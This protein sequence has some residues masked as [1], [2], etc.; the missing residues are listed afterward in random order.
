MKNLKWHSDLSKQGLSTKTEYKIFLR[1]SNST[2][3]DTLKWTDCIYTRKMP[4]GG[5]ACNNGNYGQMLINKW[6]NKLRRLQQSRNIL[7]SWEEPNNFWCPLGRRDLQGYLRGRG[8]ACLLLT[9]QTDY[10]KG[11]EGKLRNTDNKASF[12]VLNSAVTCQL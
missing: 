8:L 5:V 6:K 11:R 9:H 2:S 10:S 1:T 7:N 4:D 12:H 3:R